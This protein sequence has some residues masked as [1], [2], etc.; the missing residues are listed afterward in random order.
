MA[1]CRYDIPLSGISLPANC[2]YFD[3][4]CSTYFVLYSR[5]GDAAGGLFSS[6]GGFEE[7]KV[8]QYP[9]IELKKAWVGQP[10]QTTLNIGTTVGGSQVDTQLT[11][12]NG[13]PPLSTG[14]N[15]VGPGTF[16]VSET[17]ASTAT[18]PPSHAHA[19]ARRSHPVPTAP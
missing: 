11:G 6:D 10:G 5:W 16:Y 8:K 14:T 9:T 2:G 4:G 15:I 13:T 1:T 17:V 3:A 7:W 19:T 12:A 18:Q